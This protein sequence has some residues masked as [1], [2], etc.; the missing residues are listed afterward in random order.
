M[1]TATYLR[2]ANAAI[3][4]ALKEA[5]VFL[6][7]I[8]PVWDIEL[9]PG[10]DFSGRFADAVAVYEHGSIYDDTIRIGIN[11]MSSQ[12]AIEDCFFADDTYQEKIEQIHAGN[13]QSVFHEMGHGIYEYLSD[14]YRDEAGYRKAIDDAGLQRLFTDDEEEHYVEQFAEDFDGYFPNE[15]NKAIEILGL[16]T[17][18]KQI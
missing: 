3:R 16:V 1:K 5:R 12:Q 10:Y 9:D 14:L 2:H 17:E 7:E 8:N 13:R 15:I 11:H 18:M 6:K 4:E